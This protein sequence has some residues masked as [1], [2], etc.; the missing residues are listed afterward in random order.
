MVIKIVIYFIINRV[1]D[2]FYSCYN[3]LSIQKIIKLL[4][5][6]EFQKYRCVNLLYIDNLVNYFKIDTKKALD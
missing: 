4:K 3:I 1:Y 6:H 2:Y 5:K